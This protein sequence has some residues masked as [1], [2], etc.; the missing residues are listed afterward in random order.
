MV[1]YCLEA[2]IL[3]SNMVGSFF[4]ILVAIHDFH[5]GHRIAMAVRIMLRSYHHRYSF[6]RK[7]RIIVFILLVRRWFGRYTK[8]RPI[9]DIF[10]IN[11]LL[12]PMNQRHSMDLLFYTWFIY[13]GSSSII[14]HCIFKILAFL[15]I[16]AKSSCL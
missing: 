16:I 8:W 14:I 5:T 11:E 10:G 12:P 4:F 7:W 15:E 13:V 9:R 1:Y 2:K 6:I 3:L